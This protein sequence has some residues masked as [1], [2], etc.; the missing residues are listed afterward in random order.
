MGRKVLTKK[1]PT[2]DQV[3]QAML[4]LAQCG[5]STSGLHAEHLALAKAVGITA[6]WPASVE[7]WVETMTVENAAKLIRYLDAVPQKQAV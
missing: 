1:M 4:L 2:T 3:R 7:V 6:E 5:Y